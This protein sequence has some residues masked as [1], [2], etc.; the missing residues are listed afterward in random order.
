MALI[1]KVTA[2]IVSRH[3]RLAVTR[4]LVLERNEISTAYAYDVD[5]ALFSA[6]LPPA[7][8]LVLDDTISPETAIFLVDTVRKLNPN[9]KVLYIAESP[10]DALPSYA[11]MVATELGPEAL[12]R[13]VQSLLRNSAA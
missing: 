12:I 11:E 5:D 7:A 3:Q 13:A 4:A 1:A 6:V 2:L 8:V 9:V 10:L